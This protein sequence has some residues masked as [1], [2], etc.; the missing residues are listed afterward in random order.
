MRRRCLSVF[1]F[2]QVFAGQVAVFFKF[3]DGGFLILGL[4]DQPGQGVDFLFYA[5]RNRNVS[6]REGMAG[7]AA[8]RAGR[9]VLQPGSMLLKLC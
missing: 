6:C 4:G 9:A 1:G 2:R 7:G 3:F 8:Q 5:V